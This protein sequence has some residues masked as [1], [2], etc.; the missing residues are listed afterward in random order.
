[1]TW[2]LTELADAAGGRLAG[3]D[4]DTVV[5]G[6]GTDSRRL[7]AG[8]AFV[9]IR[10]ER[11]DGHAFVEDVLGRGA[12]CAVVDEAASVPDGCGPL[13]VV[14]DTTLA[15][16]R[17]AARCRCAS[18]I[19]WI[20]TTG[21]AGKTTTKEM[22]A[23]VASARGD[24]L[25]APS[26][27]NNSIGVPLTILGLRECHTAASVELGTNAPGEIAGLAEIVKPDIAVVTNVGP[28]HL[29]RFGSVEAIAREKAQVLRALR[30]DGVAVLPADSLQ[31]QTLRAAWPG[32]TVTFGLAPTA[33]VRAETVE[34]R[35]VAGSRFVT[36]GVAYEIALP[37]LGNVRN[38]LAAIAVGDVLGVA[39]ERGA[40]LLA[41]VRP[42]AMRSRVRVGRGFTVID[43]CYNANPLSFASAIE[44]LL[45]TSPASRRWVVAGDMNELGDHAPRLHEEL[46]AKIARSGAGALLAVGR[47]SAQLARGATEAGMPEVSIQRVPTATEAS[48]RARRIARDGDVI[49]VKASRAVGLE[50]VV[51]ALLDVAG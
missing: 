46:G 23:A 24:V 28:A 50:R 19:P 31:A 9:A 51:E 33:D 29:G 7:A 8:E 13:V 3:G 44:A 49:L 38:A 14:D 34:V 6:V 15:L 20:A 11:F 35:G 39:R 22:I 48:D 40:E 5:A 37:G 2:R 27:F 4:G 18:S 32:R 25:K 26:S 17:I 45:L 12:A 21:S 36:D 47:F 1:M 16:G 30:P 43:D 41:G 10:G 42:M